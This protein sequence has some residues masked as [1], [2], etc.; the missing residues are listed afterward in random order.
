MKILGSTTLVAALVAAASL[1]SCYVPPGATVAVEPAYRPGYVVT[2]LPYGYRTEL[3]SGTRYYY[4]NDVYYRPSGRGYIV[5]ESPHRHGPPRGDWDRDG[6][7][8]RRGPYPHDHDVTVVR[9]LPSGYRVVTHHGQRYYLAGDVY[10]QARGD[11]YI[12]VRSPF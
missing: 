4:H 7:P 12:V 2:S 1:S 5:V 8:D 11:G 6:R 9:R 3:I 10:Y